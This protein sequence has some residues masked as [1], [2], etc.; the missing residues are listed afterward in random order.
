MPEL[1]RIWK[2]VEGLGPVFMG[3]I[4]NDG[5]IRTE[6]DRSMADREFWLD[7]KLGEH[8]EMDCD[9]GGEFPCSD[10]DANHQALREIRAEQGRREQEQIQIE[11]PNEETL[12][13]RLAP[14]GTEWQLEQQERMEGR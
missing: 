1:L 4:E 3:W 6:P 2:G 11:D 8:S 5:T 7:V 14:F 13:E 9:G 12:E 10:C